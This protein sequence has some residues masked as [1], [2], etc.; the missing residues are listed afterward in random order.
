M[1]K[2]AK[3]RHQLQTPRAKT[4]KR[5]VASLEKSKGAKAS[6]FLEIL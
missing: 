3:C 2:N 6:V 1:G 5:V 4:G